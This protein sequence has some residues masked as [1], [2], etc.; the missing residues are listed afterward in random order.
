[1]GLMGDFVS[2]SVESSGEKREAD[3]LS[4]CGTLEILLGVQPFLRNKTPEM[5]E[6][7]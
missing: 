5:C 3:V 4:V 6:A 7:S 2:H 1:M